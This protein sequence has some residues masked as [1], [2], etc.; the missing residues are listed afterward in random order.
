MRPLQDKCEPS[1]MEAIQ[2]L[3]VEDM[4]TTINDLFSEFDP[5]PI[6]VASLAQVHKAR[7]K[8]G[9]RVA[10][11][12]QHPHLREFTNLECAPSPEPF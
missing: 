7:L 1:S 3:F 4:G 2:Q 6:G 10:V 8:D 5:D 12:I 11:K 9:T